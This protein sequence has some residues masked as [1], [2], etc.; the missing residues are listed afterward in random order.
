M[1]RNEKRNL[2]N[3]REIKQLIIT[4]STIPRIYGVPKIHNQQ[5]RRK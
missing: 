3:Q 1:K 4:V 5:V 2:K